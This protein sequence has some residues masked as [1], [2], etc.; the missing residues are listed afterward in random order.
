M[1]EPGGSVPVLV[2]AK[3]M[4]SKALEMSVCFH[5]GPLLG[6]MEGHSSPR[7]LERRDKF[8]CLGRFV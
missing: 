8:L 1:R 5:R 4:L 3:D 7:N 2:T 6:K